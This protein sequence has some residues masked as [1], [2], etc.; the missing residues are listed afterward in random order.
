MKKSF[1]IPRGCR[2]GTREDMAAICHLVY[3]FTYTTISLLFLMNIL[4]PFYFTTVESGLQRS[5]F[6]NSYFMS[7]SSHIQSVILGVEYRNCRR[8]LDI[9]LPF[10]IWMGQIQSKL[11][12]IFVT[13]ALASLLVTSL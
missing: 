3:T 1:L 13:Y 7:G 12:Y 10:A 9:Y 8:T 2:Q 6:I 5:S 4:P 11:I